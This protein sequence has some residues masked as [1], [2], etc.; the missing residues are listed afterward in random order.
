MKTNIK[1]S[2]LLIGLLSMVSC[3]KDLKL[4][5]ISEIS[6][7]S[8]WQ[9]ENDATGA[10]YGMY[11]RVRPEIAFN[12]FFWGEARSETI[13]V[14]PIGSAGYDLYFNNALTAEN[15]N[16]VYPNVNT[17]WLGLYAAIHDANLILKYV[18]AITF[19]SEE[20]KNNIL[21]QA[22]A[23]RAFIYFIMAKTWGDVVLVTEPT[24]GYDKSIQRERSSNSV[25]FEQ[26]KSDVNTAVS[27]Y[28]D[29]TI[30][31]GRYLWS[32][33]STLALKGDIYLWT[34]KRLGGGDADLTEALSALTQAAT[35][36]LELVDDFASI[37]A[38]GNKGN[39][40]ILM[41]IR[42][43]D[44]EGPTNVYNFMTIGA[45]GQFTP[46]NITQE[47]RDVL[48][49]LGGFAYMVPSEIV[50]NQYTN[51]D[52][53]KNVTFHDVYTE[54]EL[55][56]R[57]YYISIVNKFR[58]S[59]GIGSKDDI[60]IYRYADLL[61]MIA[62]AKNALGQDPSAEVNMVRERAYGANFAA[63]EFVNGSRENNDEAI[64][65]ERLLELAYEGKRWWDL[66]RFDEA[67]N[68]VP[69]LQNR[70]DQ[71]HL[72]LFPLSESTLSIEP[73]V[74]QNPGY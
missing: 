31:A 57:T 33:P 11:A 62:E 59:P 44:L 36:D 13:G 54:D 14:S 68:I 17:T 6:G 20:R 40:E 70:Q 55:G 50:R 41:S 4:K 19:T 47:S 49:G 52:L 42:L 63:H 38:Y 64:L 61:L 51:D 28:T 69:S 45:I 56:N 43:Q 18:P 34:A 15:V 22:Y 9:T 39:K 29:N 3:T 5:P 23:M 74:K 10:L 37:F 72:L 25:V 12:Y 67:F 65:K 8:F 66:V 7:S 26:I 71:Q 60:I 73:F 27:L 16:P 30:P 35:A 46:G 32:L 53:R 48:T 2:S 1:I 21:A 24:E 58:G